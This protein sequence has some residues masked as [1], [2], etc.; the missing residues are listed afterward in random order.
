MAWLCSANLPVILI[1][2]SLIILSGLIIRYQ[3]QI[4]RSKE[5]EFDWN[6]Q[7][8]AGLSILA[9]ISLGLFITYTFFRFGKC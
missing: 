9:I 7:I 6:L 8:L 2:I 1:L 5:A 3:V 4:R